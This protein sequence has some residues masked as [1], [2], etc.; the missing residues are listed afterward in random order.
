LSYRYKNIN[1]RNSGKNKGATFTSVD[2]SYQSF[3]H[4]YEGEKWR[5]PKEEVVT[6]DFLKLE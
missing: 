4:F 3:A 1:G 2:G 5:E 6:K